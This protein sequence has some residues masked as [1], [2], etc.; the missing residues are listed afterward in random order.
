MLR[1]ILDKS[2]AFGA[3]S[4]VTD[5]EGFVDDQNIGVGM[6]ADSKGEP[7]RHPA[8]IEFDRLIKEIADPGKGGNRGESCLDSGTPHAQNG[9]ADQGIF[10]ACQFMIEPGPERQNWRHPAV[11]ADSSMRRQ[12]DP[13]NDLQQSGFAGAVAADN[14]DSARRGGL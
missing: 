4:L 6:R 12:G 5:R 2:I 13:A 3:K 11:D 1:K 14:A 8:R 7:R 10:P 9:T